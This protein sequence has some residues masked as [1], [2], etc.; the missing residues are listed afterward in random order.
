MHLILGSQSPRRVE[1]LS[2]FHLPFDQITHPFDE[3]SV[4]FLGD[5]KKYA[6]EIAEGKAFSIAQRFPESIVLTADTIVYR[7]GSVYGKPKDEEEAL[8]F[9]LELSGKWH[10]VIT[11][12][13]VSSKGELYSAVEETNVLLHPLSQSQ[14]KSYHKAFPCLDKAGAFTITQG[15]SSII[16]NKIDGCYYNVIGLPINSLQKVLKEVGIDL[17]RYLPE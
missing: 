8:N 5:P 7:E 15:A 13:V 17:W 16:V 6:L 10:Q 3:E 4:P 1:I 11:A 9:L 12:V 2:S 14:I